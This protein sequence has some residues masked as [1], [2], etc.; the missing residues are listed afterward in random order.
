MLGQQIG[1]YVG[2]TGKSK[3]TD[4]RDESHCRPTPAEVGWQKGESHYDFRFLSGKTREVHIQSAE[5]KIS[6]KTMHFPQHWVL[7]RPGAP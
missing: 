4:N 3:R 5:K 1:K 2:N 6:K 7:V